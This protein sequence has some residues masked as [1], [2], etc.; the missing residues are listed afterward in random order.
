MAG[1]ELTESMRVSV[2]CPKCHELDE[3]E[4]WTSVN[5]VDNPDVAQWLIDGFL[6]KHECPACGN[7]V[8]LNHDCL[9]DDAIHKTMILYVANPSKAE[10][11][12]AALDARKPDGYAIRLVATQD[13][14]REKAAIFRDGLDDRAVEVSKQAL[15]NRFVGIG[16]IEK[17]ARALY[18]AR[19]EDGG[20][21][22]EFVTH[23]G[24]AETVVP[25]DVYGGIA[26]SFTDVQPPVVDRD[27]AM[28]VLS[29]WE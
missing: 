20:I 21:V 13:E 22:I 25:S 26:D 5:N 15:F 2:A 17:E 6:F 3:A 29:N 7:V 18:G 14:L 8:T 27:W 19:T 24:T 12:L 16:E 4:V 11:A 28:G 9:F 1:V 10:E 23:D